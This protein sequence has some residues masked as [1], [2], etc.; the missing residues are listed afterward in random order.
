MEEAIGWFLAADFGAIGFIVRVASTDAREV[1]P[2][3]VP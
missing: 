3:Q 1:L 2:V